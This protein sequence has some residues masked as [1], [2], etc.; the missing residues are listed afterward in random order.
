M[1]LFCLQ[2]RMVLFKRQSTAGLLLYTRLHIG[3]FAPDLIHYA[4]VFDATGRTTAGKRS[5][6][7]RLFQPGHSP[8][9]D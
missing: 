5:R 6:I 7:D 1:S 9:P 2:K 4:R 8:L 3:Y